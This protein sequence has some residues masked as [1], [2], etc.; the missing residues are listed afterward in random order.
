MDEF[1]RVM[2]KDFRV[3]IILG[4]LYGILIGSVA[5]L[6]YNEPI[7]LGLVV[8][9]AVFFVMT[10]A[11]TLGT[12]VPLVLKRLDIDAAVA[13]GPFVTTSIDMIGVFL[14]FTVARWLLF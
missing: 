5:W 9:I 4:C 8:G 12:L 2:F 7:R 11:A 3:G 6:G 10:M 13:T 1:F 14:F